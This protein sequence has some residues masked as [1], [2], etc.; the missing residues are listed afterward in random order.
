MT[1]RRIFFAILHEWLLIGICLAILFAYLWPKFGSEE[2]PLNPKLTENILVGIVFFGNGLGLKFQQLK[3]GVFSWPSHLIIQVFIFAIFPCY[4]YGFVG[5]FSANIPHHLFPFK[6]ATGILIMDTLPTT[7]TM[8]PIFT[9]ASKGSITIALLNA[10]L[11]SLISIFICPFLVYIQL[12]SEIAV[13]YLALILQLAEIVVV[14]IAGGLLVQFLTSLSKIT[15]EIRQFIVQNSGNV[16]KMCLILL[17]YLI[18]CGTFSAKG[19]IKYFSPQV[20]AVMSGILLFFSPDSIIPFVWLS[21]FAQ[22]IGHKLFKA[23]NC[24]SDYCCQ[25]KNNDNGNS[26]YQSYFSI[27]SSGSWNCNSSNSYLS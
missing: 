26:T 22:T 11:S 20:I 17:T 12:G 3:E 15:F 27:R 21:S 16:N 14:P 1:I 23:N 8:S 5:L 7:I 19:S 4:V 24:C 2:G 9:Q 10:S 18:F 6:I 13:D 25:S